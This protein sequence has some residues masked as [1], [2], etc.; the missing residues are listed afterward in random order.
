MFLETLFYEPVL[1]FRV[2][3]VVVLSICLHELAHGWAALSQGDDTPETAGHMTLN[4]VVHLGVPSLI[5]L[6]VAGIAW[7]AMPVNPEKFRDRKWGNIWVSAAGPLMN[8]S[9]GIAFVSLLWLIE[10][11]SLDAIVSWE[12]LYLAASLNF[13]LFLFNLLPLPPLDGFHVAS[14]LLPALK[15][16]RNTP[17]G[18]FALMVIFMNPDFASGLRFASRYTIGWLLL[19]PIALGLAAAIVAVTI[20]TFA[21]ALP[22]LRKKQRDR[23]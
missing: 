2:L 8:L 20:V 3:M 4:P 5:F 7:G 13:L 17:I 15:P 11:F 12:F 21:I 18:F 19:Y 22:S 23:S 14:E 9:L 16:L 1:F 6:C 10:T